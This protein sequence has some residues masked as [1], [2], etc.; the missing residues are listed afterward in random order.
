MPIYEHRCINCS[1]VEEKLLPL[2]HAPQIHCGDVMVKIISRPGHLG[3]IGPGFYATDYGKQAHN[4]NTKDQQN[5]AK[6]EVKEAG[7][8]LPQAYR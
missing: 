6:R 5:R 2:N 1:E 8:T 3:F 7:L 4:L